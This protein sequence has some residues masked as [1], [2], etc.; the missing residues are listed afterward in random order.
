M[1]FDGLKRP[2]SLEC[3]ATLDVSPSAGSDK[4][5][6]AYHGLIAQHQYLPYWD[7]EPDRRRMYQRIQ[8][9]Y[10]YLSDKEIL[11]LEI[12]QLRE[13]IHKANSANTHLSESFSNVN[14]DNDKQKRLSRRESDKA[15][16]LEKEV[17]SLRQ[18]AAEADDLKTENKALKTENEDLKKQVARLK[19]HFEQEVKRNTQKILKDVGLGW[20]QSHGVVNGAAMTSRSSIEATRAQSRPRGFERSMEGNPEMDCPSRSLAPNHLQCPQAYGAE[21]GTPWT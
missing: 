9:P 7:M 14:A 1:A 11:S 19:Q 17:R 6:S 12:R 18:K 21:I 4:I 5:E 16:K 15:K 8:D 20:Q 3:Y 2:P 13:A 10:G